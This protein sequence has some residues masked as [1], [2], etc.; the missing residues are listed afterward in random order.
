MGS[1]GIKAADYCKVFNVIQFKLK[2][3]VSGAIENY[4]D[5]PFSSS[6]GHFPLPVSSV[7]PYNALK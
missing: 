5:L 4:E 7:L 1:L 3:T 2:C 6:L